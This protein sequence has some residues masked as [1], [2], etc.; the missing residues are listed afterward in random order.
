MR[1]TAPLDGKR[2]PAPPVAAPRSKAEKVQERRRS[3]IVGWA[4]FCVLCAGVLVAMAIEL[5][6]WSQPTNVTPDN[7]R[8][9]RVTNDTIG[10]SGCRQRSF[11]NETWRM[12][13]ANQP[14]EVVPHDSNGVPVPVGTIHRLDA[15]NKPFS[16][17]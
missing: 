15:I 17:K 10:G 2:A 5:P 8:T 13:G 4:V 16:G 3:I 7:L 1:K 6:I 9:V 11:D 14:C 12:S